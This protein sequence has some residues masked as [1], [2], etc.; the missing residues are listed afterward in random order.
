MLG[1]VFNDQKSQPKRQTENNFLE[2]HLRNSN[3]NMQSKFSIFSFTSQEN[4]PKTEG[5]TGKIIIQ[6]LPFVKLGI[7]ETQKWKMR[8]PSSKISESQT[9]TQEAP[10]GT[11]PWVLSWE[12]VVRVFSDTYWNVNPTFYNRSQQTFS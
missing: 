9:R 12:K 1:S 11:C 3:F 10:E 4:H 8:K 6:S 2:Y 5:K 7:T